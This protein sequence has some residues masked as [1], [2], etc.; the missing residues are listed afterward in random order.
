V[1]ATDVDLTIAENIHGA[2][3]ILSTA[4]AVLITAT[5][6]RRALPESET[7]TNAAA[8]LRRRTGH[9]SAVIQSRSAGS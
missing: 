4:L 8:Q 6:G 3:L 7:G 2:A 1:L 9:D 5:A